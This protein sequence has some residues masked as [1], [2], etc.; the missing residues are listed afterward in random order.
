MIPPIWYKIEG[1]RESRRA[2]KK[3]GIVGKYLSI[4]THSCRYSCVGARSVPKRNITSGYRIFFIP[5][6]T[7][8]FQK[9]QKETKQGRMTKGTVFLFIF[10]CARVCVCVCVRRVCVWG[11]WRMHFLVGAGRITKAATPCARAKKYVSRNSSRSVC[12][13]KRKH[14]KVRRKKKCFFVQKEVGQSH[15]HH[16]KTDRSR[17]KRRD[18]AIRLDDGCT[19]THTKCKA[20]L[21]KAMETVTFVPLLYNNQA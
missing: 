1:R 9:T 14:S 12:G 7:L 13:K 2:K 20:R 8:Q 4:Y 5:S 10:L 11:G 19:H 18:R 17:Y 6:P 3:H 16:W 21:E 15:V